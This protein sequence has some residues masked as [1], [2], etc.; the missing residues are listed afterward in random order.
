MDDLAF[1]RER[2]ESY[3]EYTNAADRRRSDEQIRAYVG[4]ALADLRE[5]LSPRGADGEALERLLLRCEFADQRMA[6]AFDATSVDP[7]DVSATTAADRELVTLADDA[8]RRE[9]AGLATLLARIDAAFDRRW[10]SVGSPPKK[11]PPPAG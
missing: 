8:R 9:A 4:E 7:Q 10:Q 6:H 5:R 2:I 3:A 1:L 11:T